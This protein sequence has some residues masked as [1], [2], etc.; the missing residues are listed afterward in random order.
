MTA[1]YLESIG[2]EV[3]E[4]CDLLDAATWVEALAGCTYVQHCA[5][6]FILATD[7]D[8]QSV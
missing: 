1:G 5:S 7:G 2:V 4:G 3:I 8:P 6:P